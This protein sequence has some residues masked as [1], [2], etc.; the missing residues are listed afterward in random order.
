[1][2]INMKRMNELAGLKQ[3]IFQVVFSSTC[4]FRWNNTGRTFSTKWI[5]VSRRKVIFRFIKYIFWIAIS[6]KKDQIVGFFFR[7]KHSDWKI[8]RIFTHCLFPEGHP[9]KNY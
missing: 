7:C 2:V 1:M 8:G 5:E 9:S 3:M 4:Y 6:F